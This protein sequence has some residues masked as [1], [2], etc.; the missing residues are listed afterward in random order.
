[1]QSYIVAYAKAE[2]AKKIRA[3]LVRNGRHV[4]AVTTAGAQALAQAEILESGV[5]VCGY[6]LKDM[7]Y[8]ELAENLPPG[9]RMLV[10]TLPVH[11]DEAVPMDRVAYLTTPLKVQELL[12]TLDLLDEPRGRR[13][14]GPSSGAARTEEERQIISRAKDILMERN[15][16]TEPEAHRYLQKSAMDTG[17]SLAETAEKVL[18]L[19]AAGGGTHE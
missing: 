6:R 19:A 9:F 18:L 5:I 16:M 3:L 1:M 14:R 10:I 7:L 12:Q 2:D 17:S 13:R 8:R 15:H 11:M 4:A